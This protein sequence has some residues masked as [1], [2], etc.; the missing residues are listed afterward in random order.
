[1]V[2]ENQVMKILYKTLLRYNYDVIY[3]VRK[4]KVVEISS[5]RF[6]SLQYYVGNCTSKLFGVSLNDNRYAIFKL[7]YS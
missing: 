1:M 7:S 5:V 3:Y 6:D 2:V 4:L